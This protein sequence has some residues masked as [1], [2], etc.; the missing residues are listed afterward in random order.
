MEPCGLLENSL[1][2]R[3][4]TVGDSGYAESSLTDLYSRSSSGSSGGS[5]YDSGIKVAPGSDVQTT[6][7][8]K[9]GGYTSCSATCLGGNVRRLLFAEIASGNVPGRIGTAK[10]SGLTGRGELWGFKFDLSYLDFGMM[11]SFPSETHF[12]YIDPVAR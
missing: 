8:W 10:R 2:Y 6:Y 12:K 9:E 1:S 5:D 7:S 3:I 4:D 11:D